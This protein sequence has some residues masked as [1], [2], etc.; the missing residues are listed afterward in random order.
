MLKCATCSSIIIL[1]STLLAKEI[2]YLSCTTPTRNNFDTRVRLSVLILE[3]E[4][5]KFQYT[6]T[7]KKD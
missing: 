2:T 6:K 3:S 4:S 1:Y 7:N 5:D